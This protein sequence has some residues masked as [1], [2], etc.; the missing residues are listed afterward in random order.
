MWKM[1]KAIPCVSWY[2]EGPYCLSSFNNYMGCR[3]RYGVEGYPEE[4]RYV[5]NEILKGT[6]STCSFGSY[7]KRDNTSS[8]LNP[9]QWLLPS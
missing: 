2:L 3:Y 4:H 6:G 5:I 7:S 9:S 8:Y 1:H